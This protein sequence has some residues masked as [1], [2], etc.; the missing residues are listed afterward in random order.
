VPEFL[1]PAV[2]VHVGATRD[3]Q[4]VFF[5]RDERDLW[6]Y[7]V[8]ARSASKL[9]TLDEGLRISGIASDE[10]GER[11][12]MS[13][14]R[15]ATDAKQSPESPNDLFVFRVSDRSGAFVTSDGKWHGTAAFVPGAA[16]WLVSSSRRGGLLNLWK[17]PV[18]G[19]ATQL[20]TGSGDD[21]FATPTWDGAALLYVHD[22]TIRQI[23]ARAPRDSGWTRI[24]HEAIDH[25]EPQL[26]PSG[27]RLTFTTFDRDRNLRAAWEADA[28][29]FDPPRR[30]SLPVAPIAIR[31]LPDARRVV[32]LAAGGS[33]NDLVVVDRTSSDVV[34]VASKLT[35]TSEFSLSSDAALVAFVD[36]E[37]AR[38]VP[39]GGA[40]G[41]LASFDAVRVVAF[42]P[43][44]ARDLA[45]VSTTGPGTANVELRD[46]TSGRRRVI[47]K[48]ADSDR[49]VWARDGGSIWIVPSLEPTIRRVDANDGHTI[50]SIAAAGDNTLSLTVADDGTLVAEATVGQS[51]LMWMENFGASP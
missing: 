48:C 29:A 24:T 37:R 19:G 28:P 3:G 8:G 7:D 1:E 6:A 18:D 26:D 25:V 11:V 44:R 40:A 50:E 2:F 21:I 41:D 36:G 46:L 45:I 10:R 34:T 22:Q 38:I 23:F 16:G 12:V 33:R 13:V 17:T 47:A 35:T 32:V 43:R 14:Q 9:T 27:R 30:L 20:A 5:S 49:V 15:H 4:R 31:E 42:S 39:L 51:R